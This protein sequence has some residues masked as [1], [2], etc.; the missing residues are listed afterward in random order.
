[1][2]DPAEEQSV[3]LRLVGCALA[4]SLADDEVPVDSYGC[5]VLAGVFVALARSHPLAPLRG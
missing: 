2:V 4:S 3:S 5:K 1:M